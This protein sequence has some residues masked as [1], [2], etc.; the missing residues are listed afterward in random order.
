ARLVGLR[1]STP[2]PGSPLNSIN[3]TQGSSTGA[4]FDRAVRDAGWLF[5]L[6]NSWTNDGSIT[7][8]LEVDP[9]QS[10]SDPNRGNN[11]LS[12]T[13]SFQD[14]APICTVFVP[15]RTH[16]PAASTDLASFW[17]MVNLA[18]QMLPTAEIRTYKQNSDIAETQVCWW[19]PFPYPCFGPY[20]LPDDD[21]KIMASLWTRDLFSD[22][23]DSCDAAGAVTHYVGL[24]HP[25]TFTDGLNGKGSRP[26]AQLMIHMPALSSI[27]LNWRTFSPGEPRSDRAASF[28][29]ELGHNYNRKHIACGDPADPDNGYP[30]TNPDRCRLDDGVLTAASTHYA[31][32]VNRLQPTAPN[33]ATDLMSYGRPRWPSD[34]TWKA[35]MNR[36]NSTLFA[37]DAPIA[38]ATTVAAA[39]AAAAVEAF[40][41][42]ES[43]VLV[44]GAYTPT[45]VVENSGLLNYAYVFPKSAASPGQLQKWQ[46]SLL[47]AY[48]DQEIRAAGAD[49]VVFQLLD[50]EGT[51]LAEVPATLLAL[52]DDENTQLAVAATIPAPNGTVVTVR[53][54]VNG[55]V[56]A[57]RTP[58]AATPTITLSQPAGGETVDATLTVAWN[59]TDADD[60]DRLL[61]AVQY[62]PDGG[63]TW[64]TISSDIAGPGNSDGD[65]ALPVTVQFNASDLPGSN[66]QTGLVRVLASD[67]YHTAIATS[68]PFT[69]VP[70]APEPFIVAPHEGATPQDKA[71]V[72][73]DQP[74]L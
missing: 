45:N 44:T 69:V 33:A 62:S 65:N 30:Y 25:S 8:R 40:A 12:R 20:E 58:G 34:Y 2:L 1:G 51:V 24:I 26:G 17:P 54:V 7:L 43:V 56:V 32:D 6:P 73:V 52:E 36:I 60:A 42:A 71:T 49:S 14:K 46:R 3:G 28:P 59:A 10:Y 21:W 67:G 41:G 27:P 15:V 53:L 61:Y 9:Q 50:S 11:T 57:T 72:A 22:D 37:A 29:H 18:Q 13:V 39:G 23:P 68:Q 31:W 19:G 38:T 66:G 55:V 35:I 5:Q 64:R 74:L 70:R 48:A 4:G 47:G 16:A 63:A